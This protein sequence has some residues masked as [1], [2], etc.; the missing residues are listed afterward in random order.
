MGGELS[1]LAKLP[2]TNLHVTSMRAWNS[3]LWGRVDSFDVKAFL[4]GGCCDIHR[5]SAA[6]FKTK[7]VFALGCEL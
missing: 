1:P 2:D 4:G 5:S 7:V 6:S 3:H